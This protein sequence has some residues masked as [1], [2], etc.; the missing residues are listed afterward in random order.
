M[1]VI[2]RVYFL[3]CDHIANYIYLRNEWRKHVYELWTNI[4]Q[5]KVWTKYQ[6]ARRLAL[7]RPSKL[8]PPVT[9]SSEAPDLHP[10]LHTV[11]FSFSLH[12][13]GVRVTFDPETPFT[14]S[15]GLLPLPSIGPFMASKS[16]NHPPSW[17]LQPPLH[18]HIR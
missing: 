15:T 12:M 8:H 11:P 10:H 9:A 16:R 13:C 18:L 7:S 3:D 5:T 2:V 1:N 4:L 17:P 6:C 14:K